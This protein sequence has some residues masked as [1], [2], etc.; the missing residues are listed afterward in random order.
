MTGLSLRTRG[1]PIDKFKRPTRENL[2]SG[3]RRTSRYRWIP[4]SWIQRLHQDHPKESLIALFGAYQHVTTRLA[5][6]PLASSFLPRD[7]AGCRRCGHCCAQLNPSPVEKS[8]YDAWIARGALVREFFVPVKRTKGPPHYMGWYF[9]G[10]RLRICPLL[11]NNTRD[12]KPFCSVYHF[13]PGHRPAACETFRPNYPRCEVT[14][15]P[16]VP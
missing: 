1:W 2:P 8:E 14:Q 11:M 7:H 12:G 9:K 10:V 5:V 13:G 15:R 16:L 3:L 4:W 6:E